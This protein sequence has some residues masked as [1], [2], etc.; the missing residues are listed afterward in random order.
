MRGLIALFV[1]VPLFGAEPVRDLIERYTADRTSLQRFYNVP[2]SPARNERFARFYESTLAGLGRIAFDPLDN[3]GRAD[4]I[5]LRNHLEH[6]QR[7]LALSAARTAE[8]R[9]LVPFARIIVDL[10]EARRR[11][12][13]MKAAESARSLDD[14]AKQARAALAE[15]PKLKTTPVVANRAAAIIADLRNSLKDWFNFYN[16]YDPSFT[17]W[18]GEPYKAADAAMK[19]YADDLRER[20][21]GARDNKSIIGDPIGREGLLS[22]LASEMISYT[23]EELIEIANKEF[24]W[25]GREMLKASRELGFGDDWK[26][27]LEHV[28]T[29]YVEPG[30]QPDLVRDL[31]RE[32]IDYVE[33]N[34]LVTVPPLARETL[35]MDMMS[36][37]RQLQN[38]FFLGGS[39]IVVSY[40]TNTMT[41]E[42][43]MMSMRGNNIHF[44]R[45]TVFHELIPGHN[46]QGFVAAR[47]R[48]YRRLFAT[49]FHIEGWALYWEFLLW[50]RGFAQSPENRVGMLFW[51]MHRCARIIFSLSFHLGRMSPQQAIDFL[52][53]RVGFERDNAEAEVRRSF[54][55]SYSPLYQAA[56][57]LGA[58]QIRALQKELA[59]RMTM[60]QFND[61]LLRENCIPV[62]VARALLGGAP[63]R[64]DFSYQWR[65]Y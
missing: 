52:V 46:L 12:E 45:A 5:L 22:E 15:A 13:T 4:Y 58:L 48:P 6:E 21:A 65:F 29:L 59:G 62:A 57:M 20:L 10:V 1:F 64:R 9:A 63:V 3:E 33:K 37:E 41:Y 61:A 36:P 42:Q 32:A 38:P 35:I 39:R 60:K 55:G 7:E 2:G 34:D 51:R 54:G 44:S 53:D 43:R 50:D 31:A 25:C 8:A 24:E 19:S 26:K 17:W 18:N 47:S 16:G 49:P 40:P 14:L 11:M 56:Y 23:P 30:K 28:K 27:A